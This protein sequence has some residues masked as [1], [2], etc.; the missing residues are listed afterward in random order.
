[1]NLKS[2]DRVILGKKGITIIELVLTIALIAILV[3]P[4]SMI[5]IRG[6][7][8]YYREQERIELMESG[9]LALSRIT[10]QIRLSEE[11]LEIDA[12][13]N[14][15]ELELAGATYAYSLD[16]GILSEEINGTKNMIAEN[17]GVFDVELS[18]SGNLLSVDLK[19]EGS[20]HGET[21]DLKT[22]LYLRNQ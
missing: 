11:P 1:M 21:I 7:R 8:S 13:N 20:K 3:S 16:N 5:S 12:D 19:L 15:I 17:I 14:T 2:I 18:A 4:L 22:S 9:Q 10:K 6:L